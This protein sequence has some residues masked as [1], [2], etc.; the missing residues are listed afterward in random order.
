MLALGV[1]LR[2]ATLDAFE[3]YR[4]PRPL[5]VRQVR[6]GMGVRQF[7]VDPE[8]QDYQPVSP[9]SGTPAATARA[10]AE[11]A[12]FERAGKRKAPAATK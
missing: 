5:E 10:N 12:A 3:P 9:D 8:D 4:S 2:A 1:T 11:V 7:T 6:A